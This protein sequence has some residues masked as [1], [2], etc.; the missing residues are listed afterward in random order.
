MK[1]TRKLALFFFLMMAVCFGAGAQS[2]LLQLNLLL[3]E[4]QHFEWTRVYPVWLAQDIPARISVGKIRNENTLL[5][6][7]FVKGLDEELVLHGVISDQS[8]VMYEWY[9]DTYETGKVVLEEIGDQVYGHWFNITEERRFLIEPREESSPFSSKILQY[10]AGDDIFF[11]IQEDSSEQILIPF[12][13]DERGWTER[14]NAGKGCYY[15]KSGRKTDRYCPEGEVQLY[16]YYKVGLVHLI[17]GKVP[18]I[19]HDQVFNSYIS[20]QLGHWENL[21]LKDSIEDIERQ[22]WS[23]NQ[24][25]WFVP[26]LITEEVIS[27]LLSI[28][29]TGKE[30]LH[31]VSVIYDKKQNKFYSTEDFFRAGAPWNKEFQDMARAILYEEHKE[32]TDV[33][34]EVFE[35]LRFHLTLTGQ[36]LL[37]SSD[38]TPYFGRLTHLLKD[39]RYKEQIQKFA[40]LRK[41]FNPR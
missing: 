13:I 31:S 26:D 35:R 25:V 30:I 32:V 16:D 8:M 21:L 14:E 10:K 17:H 34:P 41:I 3:E 6:L 33:F 24:N 18:Q 19:P 15:V 39:E 38:F 12:T 1:Q 2:E 37:I 22:R 36:G 29:S 20:D 4:D 9:D 7:I 5:G 28:R 11:T 27:G 23:E 40:P